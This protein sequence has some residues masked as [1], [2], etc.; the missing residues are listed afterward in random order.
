[1]HKRHEHKLRRPEVILNPEAG[2]TAFVEAA[3]VRPDGKLDF[4]QP[5]GSDGYFTL[6]RIP[7]AVDLK[8]SDCEN[9]E[10]SIDARRVA[11]RLTIRP[12]ETVPDFTPVS[13]V[14]LY[15]V[16]YA[17]TEVVL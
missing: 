9:P 13:L 3:L 17:I 2:I 12:A 4:A 1:M 11:L 10:P 16:G 5:G 14:K 8:K 7:T 6:A 15:P